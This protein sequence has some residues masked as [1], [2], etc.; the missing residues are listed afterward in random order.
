M[1][2]DWR[3]K[4][5]PHVKI[6]GLRSYAG[7]QLRFRTST[8]DDV[9][10]GSL[11]IASDEASEPFTTERKDALVRFAAMFTH[12][13]I[14]GARQVRHRVRQ[15]MT[16]LIVQLS[17]NS[18]EPE[19]EQV[20]I[21][22]IQKMYPNA[23]VSI[24]SSI[25]GL[26]NVRGRDPFSYDEIP[27]GIWEDSEYLEQLI[28]E[29]NHEDLVATQSVRAI[30][31]KCSQL[32]TPRYLVVDSME[33]ELIF[34]DIDAWFIER[35]ALT[36]C[37]ILQRRFFEEALRAKELFLR[38]ITHQLRTPIHGVLASAD[39]LAE[40]L[41][42][43]AAL[44][45]FAAGDVNQYALSDNNAMSILSTI[46]SSGNDLLA[47]VNG[48][49]KLNRWAGLNQELQESEIYK[50]EDLEQH[51]CNDMSEASALSHHEDVTIFFD[52]RLEPST[53]V[54]TD[55]ELLRECL[56]ALAQNAMLYTEKGYITITLSQSDDNSLVVDVVDT[57]S[58]VEE[59][60]RIRIFEA[61]ERAITS[62]RGAGLGL[63]LASKIA[64]I[65]NGSIN[66]V[67]STSNIG[68][69]FRASFAGLI[70]VLGAG[71]APERSVVQGMKYLPKTWR[72]VQA[73]GQQSPV[74]VPLSHFLEAR[75]ILQDN[76]LQDTLV[77][78][79]YTEDR[80]ALDKVLSSDDDSLSSTDKTQVRLCLVPAGKTSDH[81]ADIA[82]KHNITFY[83][84]PFT[85]ARMDAL[86]K[87]V[88]AICRNLSNTEEQP[89]QQ[90][91]ATLKQGL[92]GLHRKSS[93]V[94]L[95]ILPQKKD[96]ERF[97]ESMPCALLVDDNSINLHI[98]KVYCA[99]R[100]IPYTTAID[101]N[102]AVEAFRSS[103]EEQPFN[104]ILMVSLFILCLSDV[105]QN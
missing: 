21:E 6:G 58:G 7:T 60:D 27:D 52:N 35:S 63:T 10:L 88:S 3:F 18:D 105:A 78:I 67:S 46:H 90:T 71:E 103:H 37:N 48:I 26:I 23:R 93:S 68:S 2:K 100:G 83:S 17:A 61:C 82:T 86:L 22:T 29:H 99:K 95:P 54:K 62:I 104:F 92:N 72:R 97:Y 1:T 50:L 15:Q 44:I 12:E 14:Q 96:P 85:T 84:G 66:L 40:E 79:D 36:L 69:H 75:G 73:K 42:T 43:R 102:Q 70:E 55:P 20:F 25:S 74:T 53:S 16:E 39:L 9:A 24:Q 57:G 49:L 33:V 32:P 56:A 28:V 11:C 76:V 19:I 87:R 64:A 89:V 30:V 13:I 91:S 8:G 34:D 77:F 5:S 31:G 47:T 101:G 59:E 81:L 65:L 45:A 98:L 94:S 41:A 38:G 4:E 80:E 51:L